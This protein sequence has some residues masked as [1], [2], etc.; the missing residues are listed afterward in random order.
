MNPDSVI[1]NI[2]PVFK[3][4]RFYQAGAG[5]GGRPEWLTRVVLKANKVLYGEWQRKSTILLNILVV[6]LLL[7]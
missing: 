6:K 4:P 5:T 2:G 1:N 3:A 7:K